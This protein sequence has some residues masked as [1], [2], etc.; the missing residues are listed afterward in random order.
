MINVPS[1]GVHTL[2]VYMHQDGFRL[3][4][5]VLTT[6]N[7]WAPLN[8]GPS[9]NARGI[10]KQVDQSGDVLVTIEAEHYHNLQKVETDNW[11]PDFIK[12][13]LFRWCSQGTS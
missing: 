1:A 3:D 10:I 6:N 11:V 8:E 9:E 5:I 12:R 2:N 7:L 4:K 13:V